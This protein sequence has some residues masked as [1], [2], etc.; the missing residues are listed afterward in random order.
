[1]IAKIVEKDEREYYSAVFAIYENGFDTAVIVYDDDNNRFSFVKMYGRTKLIIRNVFIIDAD[2]EEFVKDK[3]LIIGTFKKM[4]HISGYDWLVEN[5]Q[6]FV[7]ILNNRPVDARYTEKAAA[8]NACI[9][10]SE[11]NLVKTEQ[12]VKSLMELSW[13]FH[14]GVIE[15]IGYDVETSSVEVLFSGCWGS[16]VTLRF[17]QEPAMHFTPG[18]IFTDFIMD[19]NVF[20]ENGFVYW[21]DDY[22]VKTEEDLAKAKDA[23]YFRARTLCWKQETEYRSPEEAEAFAEGMGNL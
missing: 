10:V 9:S 8:I 4:K 21:V 1:M 12:D 19:S 13:G 23:I 7:D 15:K 22:S 16:K 17:Q 6:L 3:T 20:F 14:D 11:W 2:D 5:K 18:E